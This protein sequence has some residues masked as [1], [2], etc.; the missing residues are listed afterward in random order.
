MD[1]AGIALYAVD[2][3]GSVTTV[4]ARSM[5]E[6]LAGA[7]GGKVYEAGQTP[8]ALG[9]AS[10]EMRVYYTLS[11]QPM[12]RNWDGKFHKVKLTCARKDVEIRGEDGYIANVPTP[13]QEG[14]Y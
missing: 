10:A 13:H 2:E 7:T 6:E 1:D 5:L 4:L 14:R 8:Q 11:Y 9:D 3:S 12:E